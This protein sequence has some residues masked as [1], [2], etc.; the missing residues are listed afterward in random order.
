MRLSGNPG[1]C[2]YL[3]FSS[4]NLS[5]SHL[6]SVLADTC[7]LSFD[8]L[9]MWTNWV[10]FF[11]RLHSVWQCIWMELF[12]DTTLLS[13]GKIIFSDWHSLWR[14]CFT[15][16]ARKEL[17]AQP[18]AMGL[19]FSITFFKL[20][21]YHI[22]MMKFVDLSDFILAFEQIH[23]EVISVS[24]HVLSASK[25]Q[26]EP[27]FKQIPTLLILRACIPVGWMDPWNRRSREHPHG[28]H[29]DLGLF[30]S[31]DG[32]DEGLLMAKMHGYTCAIWMPA[33]NGHSLPCVCSLRSS[34][35]LTASARL[36]ASPVPSSQ[37]QITTSSSK[38]A[39]PLCPSQP[40]CRFWDTVI[41]PSQYFSLF[42]TEQVL[43]P[44]PVLTG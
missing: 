44:Q 15:R 17:Q 5:Y 2:K 13:V 41:M 36:L 32:H 34:G 19:V 16:C 6:V 37:M 26:T 24:F 21:K 20:E 27:D 10:G 29:C 1:S 7:R 39:F 14:S 23:S 42:Q 35:A 4:Q 40:P 30:P 28:Q 43:F 22:K 31:L 25:L 33:V 38:S 11:S 12:N 8:I 9:K 3:F 18:V